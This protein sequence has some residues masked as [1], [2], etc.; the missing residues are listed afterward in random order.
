V[1]V[2]LNIETVDTQELANDINRAASVA[3]NEEELKIEI[4]KLLDPI[5]KKWNIPPAKYEQRTIISGARKDA[6]YGQVIIEFKAPRKLDDQNEFERT[7]EQVKKYIREETVD[8]KLLGRWFGVI[9]DGYNFATIRFRKNKWE[10]QEKPLTVNSETLNVLLKAIRGLKLR[11]IEPEALVMDFGPG[12]LSRKVVT[13]IYSSLANCKS[14]RTSVLF[15]DW[16]RVFS[17]VC[18]Y[19]PEK[20]SALLEYYGLKDVKVM[21]PEKLMFATH[22]YYTF[23]MKLITSE[24]ISYFNPM[25]GSFLDRIEMAYQTNLDEMKKELEDL[26]EGGIIAQLGIRNLFEADYFSWYLDEWSKEIADAFILIIEKLKEYDPGTSELYPEKVKD[27]FKQLYQNLLPKKVRHDLGEYFTPDWLGELLL[28]EV[29]YDGNPERRILDPACGSG[30]FLVLAINRI[31][32]WAEKEFYS[33]KRELLNKITHNVIGIDLNPLAVLA[34]RANY[35]LA[36]GELNRLLFGQNIDVPVY[37]ADSILVS[38]KPTFSG[39]WEV[40]LR[41]AV[42]EFW[43]PSE[44]LDKKLLPTV[45]AFIETGFKGDYTKDQFSGLLEN[46]LKNLKGET[47]DSLIR[48]YMFM[49]KLEKEGKNKIWTRLLKNSFAPLLIEK[50]DY[51]VG[52]PPWINWESLPEKYREDTKRLWDSYGLLAKTKGMGLGK[53]KRDMSMLFTA[54]CID[55]YVK[56]HGK[57]AFLIP[58]T[59]YKTQAGAGFR[60]FLANGIDEKERKI[61]CSVLKIHDLVTLYPF[62]GAI[63]RTSLI[64]I[65]KSGKTEF[66]IPCTMWSNPRSKGIE[67]EVEIDEVKRITKRFDMIVAPIEKGKAETSWMITGQ[68]TY[69]VIQRV[70]GESAYEAHAGVVTAL[71]GVYFIKVISKQPNGL[72]IENLQDIGKKKVRRIKIIIEPDLIYPLLRGQDHKKWY[73][74]SLSNIIIPT[75][76]EGNTISHSKLKSNFPRTYQYFLN[77]SSDLINRGGEPYTSKLEK[78]RKET[79][80]EAEKNSPPFYWL[81]NVEPSLMPYKVMWKEISGKISGKGQFSVAVVSPIKDEMQG[82][83]VVIPDHKLMLI[84]LKDEDEAHY[85]ASILNSSLTRLIVAGYTIETGMD[86]HVVKHIKIS[87]FDPNNTLHSNL[88]LLSKKAHEY[89]KRLYDEN[90]EKAKEE[91]EI[92]EDRIDEDVTKLFEISSEELKE[93]KDTLNILQR[94]EIEEESE[95]EN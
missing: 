11:V 77:F 63:N 60:R 54:R 86:T 51:V 75:D 81:F 36:L 74:K 28:N 53:T 31:K 72:M 76:N 70:A 10:E 20:L 2:E 69:E 25:F 12:E 1:G 88:V 82:Y 94:G 5:I 87:K 49:R 8:P 17:Q 78:Y 33:D 90:D 95:I 19:S 92:I 85:I 67:Q 55:R 46:S 41:T 45:L 26:E 73:T 35:V 15:E 32:D 71:N 22:T 83:K 29:G 4:V 80:V 59:L 56:D 9:I 43:F 44:V 16:R 18:A 64:I 91:L 21:D 61:P 6:L 30:T 62:E 37:L 24:V 14:T 65:E 66:P 34:A 38:R 93:I 58:F 48:L 7:K 42:G 23:I 57:F 89:A 39:E 84:P 40:Y 47:I 27:L 52:N 68:R 3:E 13:Q 50:F 79:I